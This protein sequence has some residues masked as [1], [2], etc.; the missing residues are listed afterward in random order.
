MSRYWPKQVKPWKGAPNNIYLPIEA[1]EED[2]TPLIQSVRKCV[3]SF[4]L[5]PPVLGYI[6]YH[7]YGLNHNNAL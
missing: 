1:G 4:P 5:A 2:L 7:Y 6:G 3:C